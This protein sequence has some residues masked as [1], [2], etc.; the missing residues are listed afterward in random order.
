MKCCDEIACRECVETLM[1][2]SE[3]KEFVIKGQFECSFCH[4]DHC[5]QEGF[6]APAKLGPNKYVKKQIEKKFQVPLIFCEGHPDQVV[7]KFCRK[8]QCLICKDCLIENHLDHSQDCKNV[9]NENIKEYLTRH[10][11]ILMSMNVKIIR[12][13]DDITNFL[14]HEK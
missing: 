3:S 2:K 13:N 5:A 4:S 14:G 9:I 8:H 11:T 10:Q 12:L 1:V 7:S 6:E